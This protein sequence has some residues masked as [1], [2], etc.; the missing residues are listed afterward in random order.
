MGVREEKNIECL[1]VLVFVCAG[2]CAHSYITSQH[3]SKDGHQQETV[4]VGTE[5]RSSHACN[6]G[7]GDWSDCTGSA[8][9]VDVSGD[10]DGLV[11]PVE[12]RWHD[13]EGRDDDDDDDDDNEVHR[14]EDGR[15]LISPRTHSP[16]AIQ[17]AVCTSCPS[18][19]S[20]GEN[21]HR[22]MRRG[23]GQ[24]R[25]Y[26]CAGSLQWGNGCEGKMQ[27]R[28]REAAEREDQLCIAVGILV[29]SGRKN[30]PHVRTC[31]GCRLSNTLARTHSDRTH[32]ITTT[33]QTHLR[34][35]ILTELILLLL[36]L[37]HTCAN[38]FWVGR[39]G[40]HTHMHACMH[41]RFCCIL[42]NR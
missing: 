30:D 38:S 28:E 16:L 18:I 5:G 32:S 6:N 23:S 25:G 39:A 10:E 33:T 13:D 20:E 11:S 8:D 27:L 41:A 9:S 31:Q 1:H 34:E 19:R 12:H 14:E 35:L 40:T 24:V 22:R 26:Q 4:S 15:V 36:L 42:C 3:A 2:S 7:D 17:L 37:K 29:E 21:R